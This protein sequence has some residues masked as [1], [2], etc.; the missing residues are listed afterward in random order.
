MWEA[1]R[2]IVDARLLCVKSKR[3]NCA[4]LRKDTFVFCRD[5]DVPNK[6]FL[7]CG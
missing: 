4:L 1:Q 7:Q 5:W 3:R 2:P 6:Q